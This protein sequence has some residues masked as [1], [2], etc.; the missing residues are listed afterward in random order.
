MKK[1]LVLLMICGMLLVGSCVEDEDINGNDN[2]KGWE[3]EWSSEKIDTLYA[4][5][6]GPDDTVYVGGETWGNLDFP[7]KSVH[8][9]SRSPS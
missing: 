6:I 8:I 2:G 4:I 9:F 1:I 7:R 3:K 5:A